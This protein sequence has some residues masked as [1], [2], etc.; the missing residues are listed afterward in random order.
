MSRS[1]AFCER[2]ISSCLDLTR[3]P[4]SDGDTAEEG[5]HPD[6]D[7]HHGEAAAE[8]VARQGLEREADDLSEAH[9][10]SL[11]RA[12]ARPPTLPSLSRVRTS[13]GGGHCDEF[14]AR[15]MS[16]YSLV[17]GGSVPIGAF[18]AGLVSEHW[19]VP[20]AFL[21]MGASGFC[22]KRHPWPSSGRWRR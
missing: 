18:L 5:P 8:L 21:V 6:T 22:W 1:R 12:A 3:G 16:L 10:G 19:G 7:A 20:T 2:P 17:F 4:L 9:S 15:V 14:H 13:R 11:V